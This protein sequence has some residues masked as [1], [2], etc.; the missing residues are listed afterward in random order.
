[1]NKIYLAG[2][3]TGL[4]HADTI[5]W[6]DKF[7]AAFEGT[8]IQCF[9]PMRGKDH[10]ALLD[11]AI[12]GSYPEDILACEKAIMTRDRHDCTKCDLVVMNLLKAYM[13]P[14]GKVSV[15]T[16]IEIGWADANRVPI[17][18]I[19][20]KE[21]SPYEHPMVNQAVGFRCETIEQAV[22]TAKIILV[23]V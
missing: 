15:G 10:L 1:M 3:I 20:D 21:G 9:S 17:I 7:T 6:R 16:I 22:E 4:L 13:P 8:N 5:K 12:A 18:A 23:P 11:T 19:M 14:S 2:P